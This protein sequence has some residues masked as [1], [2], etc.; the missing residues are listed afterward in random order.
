MIIPKNMPFS[1][2]LGPGSYSWCSCG[3][4][5]KEPFCDGSHKGTGKE[6]V[7]FT[8]TNKEQVVLCACRRTKKPPFCDGTHAR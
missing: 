7:A 2:T 8:I 5:A 3:N 6:P 4:S 1:V